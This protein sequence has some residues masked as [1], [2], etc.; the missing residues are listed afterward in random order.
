MVSAF[1][2]GSIIGSRSLI[3]PPGNI[4]NLNLPINIVG[5]KTVCECTGSY[6][7]FIESAIIIAIHLRAG[8]TSKKSS[9]ELLTISGDCQ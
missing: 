7:Q 8:N 1:V 3:N 4:F 2:E 9:I 6:S 5:N